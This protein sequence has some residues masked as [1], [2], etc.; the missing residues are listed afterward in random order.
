VSWGTGTGAAGWQAGAA[1]REAALAGVNDSLI[2]LARVGPGMRVLDCGCG[3]GELALRLAEA[4]R[5]GG[6]VL[7]VDASPAMV[8]LAQA[9][10]AGCEGL[11]FEVA[12]LQTLDLSGFDAAVARMVVML[13]PDEH[14][15]LTRIRA[16]LRS[17]ARFACS[18][19][20]EGENARFTFPAEVWRG[21]G[22]ELPSDADVAMVQRL[23][24][25]D[26]LRGCL[27]RAG[28]KDVVTLRVGVE[29]RYPDIETVI[30]EARR[31]PGTVELFGP[32][33]PD[34]REEAWRRL[35]ARFRALDRP[36]G[37]S[38]RGEQVIAAGAAPAPDI[39][40]S[41]SAPIAE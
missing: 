4:V 39:I 24:R 15:A 29:I 9:A 34:E 13:V 8:E 2:A 33:E 5:P 19:W 30:A 27:E 11:Q 10:A 32:L 26:L 18:V 31:H 28:F 6:G 40:E 1:R 25:E 14:A 12:D 7:A 36:G 37:V 23:G 38:I 21:L 35:E 41:A 20:A 16:A 22:R 3:S 17:G